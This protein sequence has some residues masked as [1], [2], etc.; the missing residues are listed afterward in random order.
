[1]FDI[2]PVYKTFLL[3]NGAA[4]IKPLSAVLSLRSLVLKCNKREAGNTVYINGDI[5][6]LISPD[7][8]TSHYMSMYSISCSTYSVITAPRC[9]TDQTV[10]PSIV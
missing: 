2:K 9:W 5:L 4:N 7:K 10:V 1:M 6:T 3:P 8:Q